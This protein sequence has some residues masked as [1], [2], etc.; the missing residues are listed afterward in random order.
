VTDGASAQG[1][2]TRR[3]FLK[4]TAGG[5]A[6]GLGAASVLSS[7]G[8]SAAAKGSAGPVMA[9]K[10]G[11]NAVILFQG[12]S[13]TDS[14]RDRRRQN[15]PN[16]AGALG[17]GY[18]LLTASQLLAE[19]PGEGLKVFNRGISGN[20]VFQLAQRWDADCIA[21]KPDLLSILIGV[22]DIWHRLN[23]Q[24]D[25]TVEVYETDYRALLERTLVALPQVKLVIC[26]PFVL[27][28]GAVN[29]KW[30]PDFDGYRAVARKLAGEYS[31]VFVPFQSVF[32]KAARKVSPNYW[33]GD[34][35]HPTIAGAYLMAQAWLKAVSAAR[36]G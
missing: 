9:G 1:R 8:C 32:D 13:I 3:E 19:H 15:A 29:A 18:V 21:V 33:A 20:K 17:D 14:G 36:T 2:S 31:A 5:A 7:A 25:G 34:G 22:N 11:P 6:A 28:C 30:F 16:D 26:E 35:V 10:I 4:V 27:R 12:D 23:G 24:Y